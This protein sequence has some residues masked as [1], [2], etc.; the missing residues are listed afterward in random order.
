VT[1]IE[2]DRPWLLLGASIFFGVVLYTIHRSLFYPI[3]ENWFTSKQ[4]SHLVAGFNSHWKWRLISKATVKD[5]I[6][7]WRIGTGGDHSKADAAVS[8]HSTTWNDYVHL[9]YASGECVLIGTLLGIFSW[10]AG[11]T[12]CVYVSL[13][14]ATIVLMLSAVVGDIRRRAFLYYYQ[15]PE[16]LTD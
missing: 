1:T 14:A 3:A 4:A 12:A 8:R 16:M 9:Q 7:Q 13:V 11:G 5:L 15:K 2:D 6:S 10:G